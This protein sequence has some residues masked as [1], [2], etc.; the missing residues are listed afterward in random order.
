MF[1]RCNFLPTDVFWFADACN[2]ERWIIVG[3]LLT[4]WEAQFWIPHAIILFTAPMSIMISLLID[5][6]TFPIAH[7]RWK[8]EVWESETWRS[9]AQI[10]KRNLNNRNVPHLAGN[11]QRIFYNWKFIETSFSGER[12]PGIG[13][14]CDHKMKFLFR[15][16]NRFSI[17]LKRNSSWRQW[18]NA[19]RYQ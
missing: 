17:R 7:A 5:N 1:A 4:L 10:S 18:L 8:L 9:V 2:H 16:W 13:F 3:L 12:F 15:L 14:D 19:K 6:W 11:L